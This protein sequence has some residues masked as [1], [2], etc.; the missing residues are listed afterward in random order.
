MTLNS[1]LS[2]IVPIKIG[3]SLAGHNEC[4]PTHLLEWRERFETCKCCFFSFLTSPAL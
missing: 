2:V 1:Y 3:V 4:R